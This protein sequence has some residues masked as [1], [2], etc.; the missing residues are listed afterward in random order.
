MK[1]GKLSEIALFTVFAIGVGDCGAFR[2]LFCCYS[3]ICCIS[4]VPGCKTIKPDVFFCCVCFTLFPRAIYLSR[5][6]DKDNCT[7]GELAACQGKV[8]TLSGTKMATVS[9]LEGKIASLWKKPA[10][11]PSVKTKMKPDVKTE[12]K[13]IVKTKMRNNLVTSENQNET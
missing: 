9:D 4:E 6:T 12:M 13:P 8:H 5:D 3:S 10:V 2:R 1:V 11:K 7:E